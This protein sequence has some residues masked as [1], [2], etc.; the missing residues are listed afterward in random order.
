MRK[1]V[2]MNRISLDGYFAG[3]NGEIDWFIHDSEVDRFA[4]TLMHPDTLLMG[5][6][7][8]QMFEASWVPVFNDPNASEHARILATEL[9]NMTKIVFSNSLDAVT[10]DNSQLVA[11]D[12]IPAVKQQKSGEGADI[13]IFGS[14]TIVQQ[15]AKHDLIDE[16]III[17]TPAIM[18][19]GQFLFEGF[20]TTNFDLLQTQRFDS[21]NVVLHYRSS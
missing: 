11:G 20:D 3:P 9:T 1:I 18:G 16:Y 14:G 2:M 6:L 4:H 12:I 19:A 17:L 21:G 5:R 13:A 10:W 8:Y 7:T 15:L